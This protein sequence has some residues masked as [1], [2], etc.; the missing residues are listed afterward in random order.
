M[1]FCPGYKSRLNDEYSSDYFLV[2]WFKI[3]NFFVFK[4]IIADIARNGAEVN[5]F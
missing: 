3:M 4:V 1:F 2:D 5:L